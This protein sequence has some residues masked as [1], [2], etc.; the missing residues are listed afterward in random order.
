MMPCDLPHLDSG[1]DERPPLP[2]TFHGGCHCGA[3]RL[4]VTVRTWRA[5]R[6]NCS[7]CEKKQYVHVIV[8]ADDFLLEQG[9]DA[10]TTY[11][12]NTHTAKHKF[13]SR[14]GIHSFYVPRSHPEGFSVNAYCLDDA[15]LEWFDVEG[16]DGQNWERHVA[17]I[18]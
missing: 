14:C 17:E 10:I 3:V 2:A 13:C 11:T 6:C 18:R 7:M 4:K 8:P 1:D 9:R 16:F 12:F 5:S 15:K